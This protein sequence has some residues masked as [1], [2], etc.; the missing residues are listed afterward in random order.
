VLLGFHLALP[1]V[2]SQ[3][4]E[5][6]PDESAYQGLAKNLATNGSYFLDSASFHH[7]PGAPNSYFAPG[8]PACLALGYRL[9]GGP[10]GFWLMLG[11]AWCAGLALT[12]RLA[13]A[14]HL[15]D[16]ARWDLLLWLT[17]NPALLYYHA[18]LMTEPLTLALGAGLLATG[19]HWVERPQWRTLVALGVLSGLAHLTRTAL[20]L[21]VMSIGLVAMATIPWRRLLLMGLVFV[22]LH[23]AVI[24]PWLL[25]MDRIG[26]GGHATELKL[27]TNLFIYNNIH[28]QNP[29]RP[30]PGESYHEPP[31]LDEMRPAS[32][33]SLLLRLGLRSIAHRPDLYLRNCLRRVGYLFSPWPNFTTPSPLK[34]VV[35]LLTT[36]V[37]LYAFWGLF[38]IALWRG[39]KMTRG[40]WVVLMALGLWYAF[41]IFLHASVRQR[42]PSDV[43]VA[44]LALS[45]WSAR[46]R[47]R[48]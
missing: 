18:H 16:A 22:S 13:E 17:T 33:D 48:G 8:W 41:H 4:H 15:S 3:W 23:A 47:P 31:D 7:R 11:L 19:V 10:S 12:A 25:R 20:L 36:G 32:R 29:Y 26:A 46:C 5:N 1:S 39:A 45:A 44:A 2:L 21:P 28:V 30:S 37:Y 43:W 14:L 40:R 9:A 27:G 24:G 38:L 35:L 34:T 6:I 42:L